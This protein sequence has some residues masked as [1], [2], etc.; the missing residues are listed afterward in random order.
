MAGPTREFWE[1]RFADGHTPWDRGV[2]NPQLAAWLAAGTLRPCR[3]LVP[4]CGSGYEVAALAQAGFEVT[5]LD[6]AP[7]AI[8]RARAAL[9][10]LKAELVVADA[11]RW[12][13]ARAEWLVMMPEAVVVLNE[14]AAA[15]LQQVD[16]IRDVDGIVAALKE[17]YD[18]VE[19]AD[20]EYL[21]A[22]LAGKRVVV[23]T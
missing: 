3:I 15:V 22:D 14:T 9:G 23:L 8:E 13:P 19:A 4:G 2:P 12:Q 21:L 1:Q 20:V 16:G 5:G 17:E 11:L 6:Y 10:A 18:D 7:I